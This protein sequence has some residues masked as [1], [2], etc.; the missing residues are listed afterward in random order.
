MRSWRFPRSAPAT[1]RLLWALRSTKSSC[2]LRPRLQGGDIQTVPLDS[3]AKVKTTT[4]ATETAAF[5]DMQR[6]QNVVTHNLMTLEEALK[7]MWEMSL[8]D[9]WGNPEWAALEI[10]EEARKANKDS[11]KVSL[12]SVRSRG[13]SS[14]PPGSR[15]WT[16]LRSKVAFSEMGA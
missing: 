7:E 9:Y 10:L 8:E 13:R 11:L 4:T 14:P 16:N 1:S 12:K 2:A 3:N 6:R 15:E 5:W